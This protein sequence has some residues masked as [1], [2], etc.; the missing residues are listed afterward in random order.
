MHKL[1]F[2]KARGRAGKYLTNLFQKR[3]IKSCRNR[4]V[5]THSKSVPHG[6]LLTYNMQRNRHILREFSHN[7]TRTRL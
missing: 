6:R 5:A 3:E 1:M 4:V 2:V 7:Q